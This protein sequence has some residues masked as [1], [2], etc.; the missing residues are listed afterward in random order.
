MPRETLVSLTVNV[1]FVE[2][3]IWACNQ[4]LYGTLACEIRGLAQHLGCYF[5]NRLYGRRTPMDI[6]WKPPHFDHL[7]SCC[8]D[9]M[10]VMTR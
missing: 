9:V 4:L 8:R 5:V 10:A 1:I 6:I 7:L 3:G 2:S